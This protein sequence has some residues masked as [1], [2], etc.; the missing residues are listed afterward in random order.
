MLRRPRRSTRTD[1]LLPYTTL[2]RSLHKGEGKPVWEAI[3]RCLRHFET[4]VRKTTVRSTALGV[5]RRD[6]IAVRMARDISS[7]VF[8]ARDRK[9]VVKGKSVS[10][11]VDLGG[12]S[13]IKKKMFVTSVRLQDGTIE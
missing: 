10:V 2:F 13:V 3:A 9:S 4:S 1:T 5:C 6:D 11:R 7:A 8:L 12:R